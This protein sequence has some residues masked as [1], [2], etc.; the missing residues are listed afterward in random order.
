MPIEGSLR[1]F[2]LGD[3]FQLLH[4]AR[5][6]GE[7]RVIREPTGLRGAV[8]FSGGA[9][10][11][12]DLDETAP[13]LGYMLYNAGKITETDLQRAIRL[14]DDD[15]SSG[16][17]QVF[18]SMG[19]VEPN[20]LDKYVKFHV[21]ESIYELL[22]WR[23]GRFVFAD[24]P[25]RK[26]ENVTWLPVES[27]LMEGA[28]R[29]DELSVLASAIDS[30]RSVP[31]LAER[32]ATDGGIL[33]L[34]PEQ[35]EVVGRVD[36]ASDIKSIAWTLGRSEFEIAKVVSRLTEQGLLQIEPHDESQPKSA[37]ASA[38]DL[39]EDEIEHHQL[40]S[41]PS[42]IESLLES[43]PDQ[44]RVH[45]LAARVQELRGALTLAAESY[46]TALNLDPQSGRARQRLGLVRLKQGD[47]DA[48]AREWT[49][50]LRQAPDTGERR[51]LERGMTA[52]R[53]LQIIM[54]EFDGWEHP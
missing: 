46:E 39:L 45:Y 16:W 24:R 30:P 13:R 43:D 35:W 41:A 34:T 37:E 25:L 22:G 15:Q 42:R 44:P 7:L 53:E 52:L 38:I 40:E 3:I 20:D 29:A 9:V 19:V 8:L 21:E 28:R 6:T 54:G 36:G 47:L 17:V 32:A 1:E 18:E 2:E 5:K 50:Y 4:L 48:A 51:R 14:H 33:D 49:A 23:D 11:G 10:V 31:R 26:S 12:A 27:L